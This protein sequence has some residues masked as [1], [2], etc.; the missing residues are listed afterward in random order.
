MLAT[1]AHGA[2]LT[3]MRQAIGAEAVIV[4]VASAADVSEGKP[5]PGPV[6]QAR[7]L[8]GA[9]KEQTVFVGDSVW[10]MRA[11]ARA[12]VTPVGVRSGG[13]PPERLREAGAQE[14]YADPADLLA[15]L[16]E[17]AFGR[18]EEPERLAV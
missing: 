10:D 13:I 3:A 12:G 15:R 4:G 17:S 6:D 8:A 2:E 5:A 11:A 1:S 14:V 7:E 16:D 18:L 9:A